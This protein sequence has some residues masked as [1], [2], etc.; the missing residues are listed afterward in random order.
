MRWPGAG[1]FAYNPSYKGGSDQEDFGSKPIQANSS[2]DPISKKHKKRAGG[3]AQVVGP[4]VKPQYCKK[5]KN[6][7]WVIY[8]KL[9]KYINKVE[10]S[11]YAR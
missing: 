3:V 2:R 6:L 4:E 9:S 10:N 11:I 8:G 5:K 7:K 1:G